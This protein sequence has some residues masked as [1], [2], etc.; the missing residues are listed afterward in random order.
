MLPVI[1]EP[2]SLT[3]PATDA[4]DETSSA[5]DLLADRRRRLVLH[6]LEDADSPVSFDDLTDHVV[7]E[8][9]DPE[10]GSIASVGDALVGTRR[11]INVSLRHV[12]VPKL[13]E[14][15]AVTVDRDSDTVSLG[16]AGP[17]LLDRLNAVEE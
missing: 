1:S 12:H 14:A 5:F 16:E 8:A 9:D 4:R 15:D 17:S 6:C 10:N 13:A 3:T 11:R 2:E 7:L